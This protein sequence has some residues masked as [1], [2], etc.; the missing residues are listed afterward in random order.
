MGTLSVVAAWAASADDSAPSSAQMM[1]ARMSL[2]LRMC[3]AS[4]P[5]IERSEGQ[6]K[7]AKSGHREGSNDRWAGVGCVGEG[8]G[9]E[10]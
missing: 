6:G 10:A 5:V 3:E 2:R 1:V 9:E 4:L 7:E 8:T